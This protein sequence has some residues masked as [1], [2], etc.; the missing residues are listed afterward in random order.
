MIQP[1]FVE[2]IFT[3]ESIFMVDS[4]IV[5]EEEKCGPESGLKFKTESIKINA[6]FSV[7]SLLNQLKVAEESLTQLLP[8]RFLNVV[9]HV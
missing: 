2:S 1:K 3:V 5:V 4:T 7:E 6:C 8:Q 9:R